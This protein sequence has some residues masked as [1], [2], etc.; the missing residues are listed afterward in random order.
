MTKSKRQPADTHCIYCGRPVADCNVGGLHGMLRERAAL[1][2]KTSRDPDQYPGGPRVDG[3]TP[4]RAAIVE[5]W[6][7]TH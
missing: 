7:K 6:G 2:V 4:H 1:A 3:M 5:A